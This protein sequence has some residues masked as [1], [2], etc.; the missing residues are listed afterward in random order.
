[1][2]VRVCARA[3]LSLT[4]AHPN[5]VDQC[6][7]KS[8]RSKDL[9]VRIQRLTSNTNRRR[10]ATRMMMRTKD[11]R[12]SNECKMQIQM[13]GQAT[14]VDSTRRSS[15]VARCRCVYANAEVNET[16]M[17]L[18]LQDQRASATTTKG[19]D[20]TER[21][22]TIAAIEGKTKIGSRLIIRSQLM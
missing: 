11:G 18:T 21:S 10:E 4:S 14:I 15:P 20:G 9:C 19:D 6:E 1:M 16:A 8:A 3:I 12:T 5:D 7:K 2:G 17:H 13:L 22:I